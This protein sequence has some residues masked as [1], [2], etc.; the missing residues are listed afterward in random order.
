MYF[1]SVATEVPPMYSPIAMTRSAR[2]PPDLIESSRMSS[3]R[4]SSILAQVFYFMY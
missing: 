3:H 4:I 1:A 2:G